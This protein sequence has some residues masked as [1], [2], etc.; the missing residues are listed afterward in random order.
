MTQAVTKCPVPLKSLALLPMVSPELLATL[1]SVAPYK[2]FI[3]VLPWLKIKKPWAMIYLFPCILN[4]WVSTVGR[5]WTITLQ[6]VLKVR[7][8]RFQ[9]VRGQ[10]PWEGL[11][12]VK[13][14]GSPPQACARKAVS[15]QPSSGFEKGCDPAAGELCLLCA[16]VDLGRLLPE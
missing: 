15:F 5:S 14:L 12:Q 9:G 6:W 16:F 3:D 1:W 10:Y 4:T 8:L 11:V 13:T 7:V 2:L